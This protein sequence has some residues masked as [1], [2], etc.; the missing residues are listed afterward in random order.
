M[1]WP[2][3]N[4]ANHNLRMLRGDGNTTDTQPMTESQA[5][6]A[7]ERAEREVASKEAAAAAAGVYSKGSPCYL[8]PKPSI[9]SQALQAVPSEPWQEAKP[10]NGSQEKR[11]QQEK[12]LPP[13]KAVA[14]PCQPREAKAPAVPIKRELPDKPAPIKREL[15]YNPAPIKQELPDNPAPIKREPAES[16]PPRFAGV[17]REPGEAKPAEKVVA[18]F[19]QKGSDPCSDRACEPA[20]KEQSSSNHGENLRRQVV[21]P[22]QEALCPP[23]PAKEKA[24]EAEARPA[25]LAKAGVVSP[26]QQNGITHK[27]RAN[28]AK[29]KA[30]EEEP[31]KRKP[32]R[33]KA[34]GKPKAKPEATVQKSGKS[35][36]AKKRKASYKDDDEDGSE[37]TRHYTPKKPTQKAKKD[38]KKSP[39]A[40]KKEANKGKNKPPSKKDA[41]PKQKS[42]KTKGQDDAEAKRKALNSRKSSA[43][44]QAKSAALREGLSKEEACKA[45]K[46]APR[47][48]NMCNVPAFSCR[49]NLDFMQL[50]TLPSAQG[51]CSAG[52]KWPQ[53]AEASRDFPRLMF[54]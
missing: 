22:T 4:G 5:E 6:L 11:E 50:A 17:M 45:G 2:A 18:E 51:L 29:R 37:A 13:Q 27:T 16:E 14:K 31:V 46:A 43:Y 33:P 35:Q 42:K 26:E 8:R 24:Q 9:A 49:L 21:T 47:F 38:T 12:V 40:P 48:A 7:R 39:G 41:K 32:G 44:H 19:Q 23:I 25:L 36:G 52:L 3:R 28:K 15:P 53:R 20:N 54:H 30:E 34:S 10:G 1:C